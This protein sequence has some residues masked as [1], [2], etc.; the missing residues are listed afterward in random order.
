MPIEQYGLEF[1]ILL[2]LA[3]FRKSGM[4]SIIRRACIKARIEKND[5]RACSLDTAAGVEALLGTM[6]RESGKS[7]LYKVSATYAV[8]PVPQLFGPSVRLST[9]SDLNLGR[10]LDEVFD[11]DM[12]RV[13]YECYKALTEF[14]GISSFIL[15]L[16][17]TDYY[18]W[19][20]EYVDTHSGEAVPDYSGHEK[21][22]MN[23][24][25]QKNVTALCDSHGIPLA[26]LSSDGN[27]SDVTMNIRMI[28]ELRR[29]MP[30]DAHRYVVVGDCKLATVGIVN[31]LAG[32][33]MG[34][35]TKVPV[36]FA[37]NMKKRILDKVVADDLRPVEGRD[38]MVAA[39]YDDV[40]NSK[41]P[42]PVRI[43]V[44]RHKGALE[45]ARASMDVRFEKAKGY[46]E[47]EMVKM[48]FSTMEDLESAVE[49]LEERF[50]GLVK[51]DCYTHMTRYDDGNPAYYIVGGQVS[52]DPAR[53]DALAFEESL[54][55]LV[56]NIARTEADMPD[57]RDGMTTASVIR[58]YLEEDRVEKVFTMMKSGS[59][60]D[61]MFIQTLRR[62]DA[63]VFVGSLAVMIKTAVNKVLKDAGVK[64]ML[65]GTKR[66]RI[67]T[68]KFISDFMHQAFIGYNDGTVS[69]MGY[70]DAV[71]QIHAIME[72]LK[73]NAKD[74]F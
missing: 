59:K 66:N 27:T 14:Y 11:I 49:K 24:K 33:E 7:P 61:N 65:P 2:G 18:L 8:A 42:V 58:Y 55:V 72:A 10:C 16:D 13:L 40:V 45:A 5:L 19:G 9:L 63:V 31:L 53:A 25:L 60:V 70:I 51:V 30:E 34:F 54:T 3:V 6:F 50:K 38:G 15:H 74:L 67:A 44:F 39:E 57:P 62:Q 48:P 23:D 26:T 36:R 12:A 46:F 52:M 71:P 41:E 43:V 73:L 29:L 17:H 68:M 69:I 28:N 64:Q 20:E 37:G 22:N 32:S 35:I 56:T 1:P 21:S 4:L 47:K